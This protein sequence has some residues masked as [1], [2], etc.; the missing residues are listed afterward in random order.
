MS[1]LK[2]ARFYDRV[3]D[4]YGLTWFIPQ[5]KFAADDIWM[6]NPN[7]QNGLKGDTRRFDLNPGSSIEVKGPWN[8]SA[9]ELYKATGIDIREKHA[10]KLKVTRIVGGVLLY[11]DHDWVEGSA[12]SSRDIAQQMAD[13]QGVRVQAEIVTAGGDVVFILNPKNESDPGDPRYA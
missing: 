2:V 9:S 5:A 12:E 13:D 10:V 3:R 11:Q 1:F 7:N 4:Q 6:H 8:R